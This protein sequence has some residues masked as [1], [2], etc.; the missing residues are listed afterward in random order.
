MEKREERT[1]NQ[2]NKK[3]SF[4]VEKE[5]FSFLNKNKMTLKPTHIYFIY[6]EIH[7]TKGRLEV[8]IMKSDQM[9]WWRGAKPLKT[10]LL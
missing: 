6:K 4:L 9:S 8:K 10:D 1:E 3:R 7:L 5:L 2:T